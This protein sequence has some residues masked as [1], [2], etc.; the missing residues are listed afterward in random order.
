MWDA[1]TRIAKEE[2]V[3]ALWGGTAS[4]LL[5]VTNPVIHFVVY[6]KVKMVFLKASTTGAQHL[7]S[8]EIFLIGKQPSL[9]LF[10]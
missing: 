6:D 4:S 8:G 1:L 5:L 2:G 7:S 3:E 9:C 10:S